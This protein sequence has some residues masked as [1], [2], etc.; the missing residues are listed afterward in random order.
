MIAQKKFDKE[1]SIETPLHVLLNSK[2]I[3]HYHSI[4]S[5]LISAIYDK[6]TLNNELT[7]NKILPIKYIRPGVYPNSVWHSHHIIYT[8]GHFYFIIITNGALY[9]YLKYRYN[10]LLKILFCQL[11]ILINASES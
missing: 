3:F 8:I 6:K 1:L 5:I 9:L 2:Y 10:P 11:L 4:A 7:K